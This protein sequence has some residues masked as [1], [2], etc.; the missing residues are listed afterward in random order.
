MSSETIKEF[1]VGLG[2]QVD[3]GGLQKFNQGITKATIAVTA[4]GTAAVAAA[5]MFTSFVAGVANKFDAVGDLADRVNTTAEE[6]LRLG[7]VATLSGSSV[8]AANSSIENLS[9]IAGEAALGVGRG[10]AAFKEFGISAKDQNGNL[11]DTSV[12]LAEVGDKIKDMGRGEQIAVLQKLGIDPTMIGVLTSDISG[13]AEE[14]NQLYKNA[15]IDANKAAEQSGEFNDSMDRLGMTFDAIKSA[16]GLKFMGQLRMGIDTLRK[17]LVENM[18]KIINAVSPIIN[19]VLRIAEAFIKIVGRIGSAVGAIIG[20]LG[21]LNDKTNG[22]AGYILA[23]AAAWKFLNLSFL[24]SPIGILLSLAAVV[25]LLIDDFLTFKEGGDS[26]IDWGSGFGFVM[27][28]V[29]AILTGLLAGLV[30]VKA[31]VL[32]KAAAI[33]IVNGA[34][35]AWSATTVAF[36]TVMGI[37]KVV[38]AAFNAVMLAN[39][40]GLVIAA[41]AALIGIGYLLVT[42]WETVKA[43]FVG[44]FN[45]FSE[46][47]PGIT[48]FV[49]DTFKGAADAAIGIFTGVKDWFMGFFNWILEKFETIKNIAGAVTGFAS[50]ATEKASSAVSNAWG[51]AKGFF[52]GDSK[53]GAANTRPPSLAPSPQAAAAV[54]GG[55]Q[56]VNQQTQIVVQGSGNPDATARAVAGQQNRV[57]ADMARNMKGAAR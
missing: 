46:T 5:G 7:Y 52:G 10:A 40:I 49:S 25:A 44:L 14:F 22:W 53:D 28:G 43:W 13:L 12:L 47:F 45:W 1:L 32:A 51:S 15:G 31:A 3:E 57:N 55:N 20:F 24:A 8:E 37:A 42:N 23:A 27:Q 4:I 50:S 56:N 11:K 38:M 18:P 41:V 17:F 33:A 2:F 54:T 19:L 26:L 6:I 16:V 29:T 9:R 34:I 35:A 36:N 21:D 39:P 48:G 30:A